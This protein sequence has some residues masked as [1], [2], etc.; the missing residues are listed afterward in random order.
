[1]KKTFGV[2]E[3]AILIVFFSLYTPSEW[4]KWITE[5]MFTSVEMTTKRMIDSAVL[6]LG[7]D[8]R[9]LSR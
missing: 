4:N 7:A 9:T 3:L 6:G 1:M 2:R 8:G 5:D